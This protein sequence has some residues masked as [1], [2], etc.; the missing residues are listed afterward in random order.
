[1]IIIAGLAGIYLL[2]YIALS[3][4]GKYRGEGLVPGQY[5]AVWAPARC[6]WTKPLRHGKTANGLTI[7]GEFFSPLVLIDR[8]L[9]HKTRLLISVKGDGQVLA[10]I[11]EDGKRIENIVEPHK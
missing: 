11:S 8:H 6:C 1:L 9:I 10:R 7:V 4:C 5:Y 3:A 2:T